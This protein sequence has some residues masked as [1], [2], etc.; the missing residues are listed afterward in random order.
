MVSI[1]KSVLDGDWNTLKQYAENKAELLIKGRVDSKKIDVL[2]NLNSVSREQM[3]EII[4]VS[5]SK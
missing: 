2:A 5:S 4:S 3:E 1:I